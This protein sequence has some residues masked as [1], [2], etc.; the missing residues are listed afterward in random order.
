MTQVR[1]ALLLVAMLLGALTATAAAQSPLPGGP[2]P[3][4][5]AFPHFPSPLYTFIWRN[6]NAVDVDRLAKIVDATPEQIRE[7]AEAMGLPPAVP[8]SEDLKRRNYLSL[9]RRNWHLLPYE[10]LLPLVNMTAEELAFVLREEDF[11]YAKLGMLKP[12]CPRLVYQAPDAATK[13]RLA[14]IKSWVQETF[15][16]ELKQPGE[17]RFAFV[18]EFREAKPG[19]QLRPIDKSVFKV[20]YIYSYFAM[21]GDALLQPELDPFPDG[22]LQRLA[23]QGVDGVW[24]H[25]VLRQLAPGGPDFP[26]FG[27][28]HEKRIENLK[29]M[30]ARAKRFGIDIYLY[31]NEPRSMPNAFFK[32]RP[33][34]A[35]IVEGEFTAMCTSSPKVRAWLSNS[36]A[37]I[38]TQV[39][40]LGGV[41]TISASENLTNC[42][43]HGGLGGTPNTCQRCKGHSEEEVI[44]DTNALIEEGVHRG[45]PEAKVIVWD[46][47][48]KGNGLA[49]ETIARLPKSVWLA[50]VSEWSAPYERGGRKE[51]V[52]EYAISVVGPGPRAEQEWKLA[53]EAGLKT[54]AKVQFNNTW[55]I[56]TVPYIP[57]MDLVAE[58]SH[59]LATSGVDGLM[60]SWSLGGYPSPNLDIAG[61]FSKRP[62]PS[63]EEALDA[64]ARD[65]F[66]AQAAPHARQAWSQMSQAFQEYPYNISFTYAGPQQVGPAN[67]L[68]AKPT[69]FGGTMTGIPYDDLASWCRP[70]PPEVFT[71]QFEKMTQQWK[72]ALAELQKVVEL[73]PADKRADAESELRVATACYLHFRSE[74][75]Q[76]RFILARNALAELDPASDAAK[77]KKQELAA[78]VRDELDAAHAM[79]SLS[80]A[81]ARF[82]FEAANHYYYL[83]LDFAEKVI[84]CKWLLKEYAGK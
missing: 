68:F 20:K 43:S 23:S 2:T 71:A 32:D 66:G 76:C 57:V 65:R 3:E 75:N 4:P 25:V 11:F 59:N 38:F 69:G 60:L 13:A 7:L 84:N 49:P 5:L 31:M 36:L 16:E 1:R 27:A 81:D 79:F 72:P 74:T 9:V 17:P 83:P 19:I 6:W 24:L 51:R 63:V 56:C 62:I 34:T 33:D 41:F 39:P 26:E 73:T 15:G 54:V 37:Y 61:R 70:F 28:D 78:I 82:G 44:A 50:S 42:A 21:Y 67:L 12:K 77:A 45:N 8:V 52:G 10:Q 40:G 47:G 18:E 22:L 35:G 64:A 58:H 55:E 53:R 14:E 80:N 29:K 48:W 30:V 46:W